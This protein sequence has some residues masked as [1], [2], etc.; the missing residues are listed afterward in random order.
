MESSVS[1]LIRT[2]ISLNAMYPPA[3]PQ[4]VHKPPTNHPQVK[5]SESPKMPHTS[6]PYSPPKTHSQP[7]SSSTT[8]PIYPSPNTFSSHAHNTQNSTS[9]ALTPHLTSPHHTQPPPP[10]SKARSIYPQLPDRPPIPS[11]PEHAAE[12][13]DPVPSLHLSSEHATQGASIPFGRSCIP[14]QIFRGAKTNLAV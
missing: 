7:P 14:S 10:A 5:S 6:F 3:P 8:R 9:P 11:A 2:D 1:F 4:R 13:N 12:P